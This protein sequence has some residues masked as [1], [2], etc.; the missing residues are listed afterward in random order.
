M[1]TMRKS[2]H[3]FSFLFRI[4]AGALLLESLTAEDI[5]KLEIIKGSVLKSAENRETRKE[6]VKKYLSWVRMCYL[7]ISYILQG[8]MK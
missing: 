1:I 8:I 6:R 2:I 4:A 3:G 7:F 5:K